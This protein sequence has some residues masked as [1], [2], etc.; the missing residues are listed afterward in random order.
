VSYIPSRSIAVPVNKENILKNRKV[1]ETTQPDWVQSPV[2]TSK[3]LDTMVVNI[4]KKD[5]RKPDM[6]ILDLLA[7]NNWERPVYF[8]SMGGDMSLDLRNYYQYLGFTYKLVP[9]REAPKKQ[10]VAI[11]VDELYDKVMNVYRWGNMNKKGV[12]VDYNNSLTLAMV[13]NVRNMHA[14]LAEELMTTA[15]YEEAVAVLDS[16]MARM[17]DY[18]F[19]L[20]ISTEQNDVVVMNIIQLYYRLDQI[21]KA[22]ALAAKF[23]DLTGKNLSFFS[24]LPDASYDLELNLAYMQQM[25]TLLEPYNEELS[26]KAKQ[27]VDFYLTKMGYAK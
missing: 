1:E 27:Q 22:D 11:N 16:A 23:V 4:S 14:R 7:N 25:G 10:G 18:N 9:M 26:L 3:L 24:K 5:I 13:L 2:D 6:M 12:L 21:D 8:V 15:R 19:P 20:N 17:P